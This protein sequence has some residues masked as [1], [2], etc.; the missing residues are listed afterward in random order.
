[1]DDGRVILAPSGKAFMIALDC[2]SG[3]VL[4]KSES[5]KLRNWDMTHSSIAVVEFDGERMYVCCGSGGVAGISAKDGSVLWES[6]EWIGAMATCPTPVDVGDGRIFLTSGYHKPKQA[7]SLMLQLKAAEDRFAANALFSLKPK[8]FES[9]QQTP[10]FFEG[11]LYGVRTSPGGNQL[12]CLDLEGNELWN[13]GRDK[14]ERGP[15]LIADGLIFVMDSKGLLTMAEATPS[16]YKRLGQFQVFED[17][18]DAW[19]PMALAGGR[20]ILRDLTRMSCLN[21]GER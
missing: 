12:V 5:E 17:A 14:F 15:Y 11:R 1:V 8:Q 10:I 18:H 20:L 21:V 2:L 7:S 6:T 9:E 3:K 4:W 16:E 19:G 13:S